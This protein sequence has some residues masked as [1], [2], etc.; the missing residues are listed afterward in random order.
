MSQ[1]DRLAADAPHSFGGTE[2]NRDRR[3]QFELN[4]Q[5]IEAHEGDTILSAVLAAGIDTIGSFS[6]LPMAL[7]EHFAP[8]VA[9]VSR[10]ADPA[11]AL[12]ME[13]T[14]SSD[15]A[16]LL[17]LGIAPLPPV[18]RG[19]LARFAKMAPEP[20]RALGAQ[21][22]TGAP[23]LPWL[24]QPTTT[25][26]DADVA[27]VGG[28]I[29]GLAAA[30]GALD[31]KQSVVLIERRPW[32]GGD[33]RYFGATDTS[34]HLDERIAGMATRLTAAPHAS[35]LTCAEAF[36]LDGHLLRVHRVEV[37]GGAARG[38]VVEINAKHVVLATGAVERLPVFAGNRLPR[39][40]QSIA[41]FH[42]ADRYGVWL[43]RTA[44][45]STLTSYGYRLALRAHDAGIR[46]QRVVDTRLSPRSRFLDFA[47]ASGIT[48]ASSLVPSRA[49]P[50]ASGAGVAVG[51]VPG[52]EGFGQKP[53][54]LETEQLVVS[55]SLQPDLML[56]CRAGGRTQ[57]SPLRH[58]LEAAG[59]VENIALAGSAAGYRS[60]EACEQSG[61]AAALVLLGRPAPRISDPEID[62][63]FETPDAAT[64]VAQAESAGLA[65]LDAG[66]TL[67]HRP[68]PRERRLFQPV[69]HP[70]VP[71]DELRALSL[72]DIAASVQM[73]DVD[74]VDAAVLARER[75]PAA[76][77]IPSAE[78]RQDQAATPAHA[79][80]DYLTNRFGPRPA[81]A[82]IAADDSRQLEIGVLL[83]SGPSVTDA[84]QAVGVV[85]ESVREGRGGA[86]ALLTRAALDGSARLTARDA[87]VPVAVQIIERLQAAK[88]PSSER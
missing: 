29:A 8:L 16:D 13:R 60:A 44:I 63:D 74:A 25:T 69:V 43:G 76:V 88:R 32:L 79:V 41:A 51:F 18:R 59:T 40:T 27:V 34:E 80:P 30:L 48:V 11:Y 83:F 4:G 81:S 82:I 66:P 70:P 78:G 72:A 46:I 22:D 53:E 6:D 86:L 67:A 55:G 57:W 39:V 50:I 54:P 35:I 45:V 20:V 36:D 24:Q 33:A 1:P 47:K 49:E 64:S 75:R 23:R 5:S 31:A 56:W 87:N 17:T 9:P 52:F 84:S 28:G 15:G 71:S 12:P 7:D 14:L 68:V 19:L 42:R 61:N 62:A 10:A 21:L 38:E 77:P 26:L 85:I 37:A 58:R 3:M 2:I 73:G 65:F